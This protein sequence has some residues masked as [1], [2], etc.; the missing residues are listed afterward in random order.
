ML[1]HQEII[2][3]WYRNSQALSSGARQ[4]WRHE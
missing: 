1:A 3:N 4:Y 2:V